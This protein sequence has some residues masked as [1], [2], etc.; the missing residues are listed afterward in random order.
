MQKPIRHL[1]INL[2][3]P[4]KFREIA[5]FRGAIISK[6]DPSEDLFH[7]HSDDV[8][9]PYYYR[10]PSIQYKTLFGKACIVCLKD[11][12]ETI[13]NLFSQSDWNLD[14]NGR[15][16]RMMLTNLD[17]RQYKMQINPEKTY[18]Y[19]IVN[20]L[21]LNPKNYIEYQKLTSDADRKKFLV[22]ILTAHILYFARSIKCY[23]KKDEQINIQFDAPPEEFRRYYK[24]TCLTTFNADFT[25][26]IPLPLYIGIGKASSRGFGVIY[27][28]CPESS[29]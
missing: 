22:K 23:F 9:K 8:D 24:N 6:I 27:R 14:I 28:H 7:Q 29:A 21:A 13:H 5:A 12:V 2:E 17:L 18:H 1:V 16:E 15:K 4:L 3:L 25:S 10:Y 20:W 26:N 11:G 19:K